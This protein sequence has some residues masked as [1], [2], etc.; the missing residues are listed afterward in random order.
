MATRNYDHTSPVEQLSSRTQ[1]P[2]EESSSLSSMPETSETS[3]FSNKAVS[4]P[5][6]R[7][8]QFWMIIF[9][10]CLVDVST[11]LDALIIT[12]ALPK[13]VTVLHGERD[14]VWL[15]NTYVFAC[16]AVM[17]F[18]GQVSNIFGRRMPMIVSVVFF[19]IGNAISGAS[20]NSSMLIAGRAVTGLGG[21]GIFVLNDLIISD[22]VPQR[23][24]AKFLGIR[25][26]I[27]TMSTVIGP[28]I[29]GALAQNNWRWVFLI[30][31]P[32]SGVALLIM[33]PCLRLKY[34]RE[35]TWARALARIDFLGNVIFI[36]SICGVLFGLIM[37][38]T[39][40]HWSSWHIITPLVAGFAGW[41]LFHV[42]QAS[43]ICKEPSMP[44]ALFRNRT[45]VA[46]LILAFCSNILLEWIVY[47]LPIYFQS[48]K[49][50]TPLV[51]GVN[52]LPFSIFYV[53]LAV[54]TGGLMSKFGVFKPIHW[55]GFGFT[56]IANGLLSLLT[57]YSPK[58]EWILFQFV[59]AIGTGFTMISI[60][61]VIQAAVP[62]RLLA[63]ATSTFAFVRN[64]GFVW[65]ITL[66][67]VIFNSQVDHRLNTISDPKI[68]A[69]MAAG[70]AYGFAGTGDVN[71]LPE[72]VKQ[73][74][75]RVYKESLD[76]IWYAAAAV[77]AIAFVVVFLEKHIE[78]KMDM[79]TEFGM[80]EVRK[81]CENERSNVS[82]KA[83]ELAE[84]SKGT[85]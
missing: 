35:P 37:G 82:D 72:T 57:E 77:A 68:A 23:E 15:A 17:P 70:G 50:T 33:I 46:G 73:E 36:G 41:A 22:L 84:R 20:V 76:A 85:S 3:K 78:L 44:P 5:P 56:S 80:E 74:V 31:L 25:I 60:L 38:G 67:P 40:Y 11:A 16:T 30:N 2:L 51:S 48:L 62:E 9:S 53:P 13:I 83:V 69:S 42:H 81:E 10:G 65:G 79:D 27:A 45:S 64:F 49:E 43:P 58:V 32:F 66:P 4:R 55:V 54:V 63:T 18:V 52:V 1:R 14:Y 19:T 7:G 24:R 21:G 75:L 61:P 6:K 39:Q 29:G 59:L 8:F 47:F 12:T 26:A 71:H 34:R 28:V